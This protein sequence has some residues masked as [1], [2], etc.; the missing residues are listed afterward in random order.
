MGGF[1]SVLAAF[2]K[3]SMPPGKSKNREL[4][5]F[6]RASNKAPRLLESPRRAH[7][8]CPEGCSQQPQA[9]PGSPHKG[10]HLCS[11]PSL[12]PRTASQGRP[13]LVGLWSGP[14]WGQ[15]FQG[16]PRGSLLSGQG[17]RE[18]RMPLLAYWE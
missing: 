11:P 9:L 17:Q 6:L 14:P 2:P 1:C 10:H 7:G 8:H 12:A 18:E 13:G 5:D 15:L 3:A 4:C 16:S